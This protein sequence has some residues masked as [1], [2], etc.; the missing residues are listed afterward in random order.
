[1]A[2]VSLK[3]AGLF[4]GIGGLELG[5]AAGGHHAHLLVENSSPAMHLLR[6]RFPDTK[7]EADVRDVAALPK[8]TDLVVAGFPCQDLSSVGRKAGI[9][10]ARSSLVGEVLRLLEG[11]DVPWVVARSLL[12]LGMTERAGGGDIRLCPALDEDGRALVRMAFHSPEGRLQVAVRSG[13][14]L[15]FLA[16]TWML[17]P[18]GAEAAQFDLDELVA[19]LLS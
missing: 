13:E 17:V 12:H 16:R 19:A 2:A 7:L 15:S 11:G 1:M 6:R 18:S 5:M 10:G 8:G 4:A 14:L 3:V 9:I